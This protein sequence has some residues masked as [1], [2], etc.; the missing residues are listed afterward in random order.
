[1]TRFP[2]H[3]CSFPLAVPVRVPLAGV[4]SPSRFLGVEEWKCFCQT[5]HDQ[6]CGIG[7]YPI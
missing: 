6:I 2:I 7:R 4:V 3:D 1:M 5:G